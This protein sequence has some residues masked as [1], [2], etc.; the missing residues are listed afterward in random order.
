[1]APIA[2]AGATPATGLGGCLEVRGLLPCLLLCACLA[3][4]DG[5]A[6][7]QRRPR[8]RGLYTNPSAE[9][10]GADGALRVAKNVVVERPGILTPRPGFKVSASTD[11]ANNADRLISWKDKVLRWESTNGETVWWDGLSA[12]VTTDGSTDITWES[13]TYCGSASARKNLYLTCSDGVRKLTSTSDVVASAAGLIADAVIVPTVYGSGTFLANNSYVAYRAVLAKEDANGLVRRS[14]AVGRVQFQNVV[15]AARGVTTTIYLWESASAGDT[16]ELYRT[17]S[18]TVEPADEYYLAKSYELASSD[19]SATYV[20]I[21]DDLA[22]A[23]LGAALYTNASREGI[24]GANW[25]SPAAQDLAEF[26]GSL[27]YAGTVGPARIVLKW[28]EGGNK[29]G[30]STGIGYRT[31]TTCRRIATSGTITMASTTGLQV[32][33]LLSVSGTAWS[34]TG[35]V[36]ITAVN[37]GVSVVVSETWGGVSDGIDVSLTFSDSIRIGDEYFPTNGYA[38]VAMFEINAGD[39][40]AYRVA[41]SAYYHA[42]ATGQYYNT[43]SAAF[44]NSAGVIVVIEERLRNQRTDAVYATHGTEYFPPLPQPDASADD[45]V[46]ADDF[47]NGLAYSKPE[48]P[49]HV[50]LPYYERIG[51][52][53]KAILRIIPTRDALWI[54]KEDGLW[55]LTGVAAPRWRIDPIDPTLRLLQRDTVAKIGDK[56]FAWTTSGVIEISDSGGIKRGISDPIA[57]KLEKS[58]RVLSSGNND[59]Y[60]HWMAADPVSEYVL[61]G[62]HNATDTLRYATSI[63]CYSAGMGEWT[64]WEFPWTADT[65]TT[66]YQSTIHHVVY[67]EDTARLVASAFFYP[68]IIEARSL[69]DAEAA[70]GTPTF[71]PALYA[72]KVWTANITATAAAD[73]LSSTFTIV[74]GTWTPTIGDVFTYPAAAFGAYV[75]MITNINGATYTCEPALTVTNTAVTPYDSFDSVIE[76][77]SFGSPDEQSFFRELSVAFENVNGVERVFFESFGDDGRQSSGYY[78]DL[79]YVQ[80]DTTDPVA[81]TIRLPIE[82]SVARSSVHFPRLTIKAALAPWSISGATMLSRP[83]TS[84]V[85]R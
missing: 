61:L 74:S 50:P 46:T 24:E 58:Q 11:A 10:T 47:P 37:A 21:N 25:R 69:E 81:K 82:T 35:A 49:E 85:P 63:Y 66:S 43:T 28:D 23:D 55:R 52:E 45:T 53:T 29:T 1:M 64:E 51:D 60:G 30:S 2:R 67:H 7:S 33:Q 59:A 56:I 6:M 13:T 32:G 84:R 76:W 15:G 48:E 41:K 3:A 4:C 83:Y 14:P 54:F 39:A 75:F 62:T 22:D 80:G 71:L 57:D 5:D 16:L 44:V 78:Y 34:G 42:Y 79:A 8:M 18:S 72:D 73:G 26:R 31:I 12:P 77:Q 27:F 38:Y 20:A 68:N 40:A 70:T 36:R 19:V 9:L 17:R 65:E